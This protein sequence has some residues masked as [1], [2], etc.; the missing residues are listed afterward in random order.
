[1]ARI[2]FVTLANHAEAVNGL[3]Y[4]SGAGWSENWRITNPDGSVPSTRLGIGISILVPW[5]E[6]NRR[7]DMTVR[8]E[9]EDGGEPVMKMD[10]QL[11]VGR[12]PGLTPGVD[13][14]SVIA[15]NGDV[16]LQ[17][18]GGYRIVAQLGE[19]ADEGPEATGQIR[20]VSFRVHDQ[21]PPHVLSM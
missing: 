18:A 4:L 9:S 8:V 11:E 3:L 15:V 5:G 17:K 20:S 2:E 21:R 14:R 7:I 1:M 19:A 12:P 13:L 16:V 6:A 10:A